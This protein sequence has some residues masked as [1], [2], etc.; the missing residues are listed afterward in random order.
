MGLELKTAP[1]EYEADLLPIQPKNI[2]G[3]SWIVDSC[4]A[5]QRFPRLLG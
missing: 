5:D 4:S 3:S 2:I 1:P